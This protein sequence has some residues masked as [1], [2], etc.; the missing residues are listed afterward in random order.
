MNDPDAASIGKKKKDDKKKL[1][2]LGRGKPNAFKPTAFVR[3]REPRPPQPPK[4]K[5]PRKEEKKKSATESKKKEN[6]SG[7][8][9]EGEGTR[10]SSRLI[11]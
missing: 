9:K 10:D 6:A 2:V 7:A 1:N 5:K 11:D 4:E 3:I 8:S